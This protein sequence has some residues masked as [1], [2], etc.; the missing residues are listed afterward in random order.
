[1][2]LQLHPAIGV[3]VVAGHVREVLHLDAGHL[4]DLRHGADEI[5]AGDGGDG[6][7]L[8]RIDLH[9][10]RATGGDEPDGGESRFWWLLR[11]GGGA[12]EP[13]GD[14][15]QA[16]DRHPHGDLRAGFRTRCYTR[17][18]C[19][20]SCAATTNRR[21]TSPAL[22]PSSSPGSSAATSTRRSWA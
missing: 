2:L 9:R 13:E 14:R 15:E 12:D 17:R 1:R 5:L 11:F 21:E 22:S 10:D 19:R 7:L 18:Q 8:H 3:H 6:R 20:S 4:R 16:G